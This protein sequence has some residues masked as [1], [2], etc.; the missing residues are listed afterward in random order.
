MIQITTTTIITKEKKSKTIKI[1][2]FVSLWMINNDD[3]DNY[4][5][6]YYYDDVIML[7]LCFFVFSV[8]HHL[9]FV[10]KQSFQKQ[11]CW[12][13]CWNKEKPNVWKHWKQ[14]SEW[15]FLQYYCHQ[16]G[17][18]FCRR[19]CFPPLDAYFNWIVIELFFFC[20]FCLSQ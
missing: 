19:F 11:R 15:R 10:P 17:D 13:Q 5:Y 8:C 9:E 4:Y 16:N 12:N 18:K 2:L 14:I 7:N 20:F 6:G 3:D 1:L